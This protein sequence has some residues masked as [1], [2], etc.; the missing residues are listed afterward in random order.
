M[1]ILLKKHSLTFTIILLYLLFVFII[2]L[3]SYWNNDN[4]FIYPLDDTYIHLA[5][6]NNLAEHGVFGISQYQFT[7]ASSSPAWS[8]VLS[9]MNII[10][11]SNDYFPFILCIILSVVLLAY[12]SVKLNYLNNKIYVFIVLNFAIFS[13]SIL[14]LTFTGLEHIWQSLFVIIYIFNSAEL[15]VN[16]KNQSGKQLKIFYILT[17]LLPLIRYESIFLIGVVSFLLLLKKNYTLCIKSAITGI[18]PLAVLGILYVINGWYFFPNSILLKTEIQNSFTSSFIKIGKSFI[19]NIYHV[20]HLDI[21]VI[22]CIFYLF[23][24]KRNSDNNNMKSKTIIM[25]FL[26]TT[27]LHLAFAKTVWFFRYEAY[28]VFSGIMIF[29]IILPDAYHIIIK[30]YRKNIKIKIFALLIM[31]MILIALTNRTYKSNYYII[32]A[33]HNIYCQQ[34]QIASFIHNYYNNENV[35]LNDLGLICYKSNI[36]P[37]DLLGLANMD[38]AK[39]RINKKFNT[40]IIDSLLNKDSINLAIIYDSWFED[41]CKLPQKWKRVFRWSMKDNY[42][43]GDS[44]VS[45]YVRDSIKEIQLINNMKKF[46]PNLKRKMELIND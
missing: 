2:F 36:K 9:L 16:N 39:Y 31:T 28:L 35:A 22:G 34:Y 17:F 23:L 10:W 27:L 3:L 19:M 11:G 30:N 5:L 21:L 4:H 1:K 44:I 37:L 41:T 24:I 29:G 43:C 18:F 8:A 38:V 20:P 33:T 40:K 7:A 32:K 14:S 42:I 6:A 46:L 26:L 45:F 13:S 12:I 15:I 25:I